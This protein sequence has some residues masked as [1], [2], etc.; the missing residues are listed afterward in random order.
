[1]RYTEG[2]KHTGWGFNTKA[3]DKSVRPQD[4]FYSYANGAWIK[5]NTIPKAE[6]R[7]GSFNILRHETDLQL[8][9]LVDELVAKRGVA[10]DSPEQ[11]VRDLYLSGIDQAA[12]NKKGAAPLAPYRASIAK[13]KDHKTLQRAIAE[14]HKIG[15]SAPWGYAVDQDAKN[16]AKYVLHFYQ[17]GLG[18]PDRDYYLKDDPEFV[19]VRTA[20]V[21][22]AKKL[23]KLAG[24][25]TTD[26]ARAVETVM[27]VETELARISMNK[28]DARDA[29]K[30]Y[31]KKTFAQFKRLAPQIDWTTYFRTAKIPT[32]PYVIVTQPDFLAQASHLLATIPLADWRTYL[33]WQLILDTASYLSDDFVKVNFSFFGTTLYGQKAMKPVWRRV[34]ASVNG[35]VGFALG[36]VYVERRFTAAS[37]KKMDLLVSDL[38][39]AY[40]KRMNALDW[41]SSTTKKKA[42]QKLRAVSRKI[43]YPTKW[44]S[45]KGLHIDKKDFFGNIMRAGEFNRRHDMAKLKKPIDRAEWHM[46]PQTVNA[47]CNFSMNE[48]VFPAAF[49]QYPFFDARSDDAVNYAAVGSTIGHELSHAFDDQGSKFDRHGNMKSW[50]T[51]DDKNK[52]EHKAQVLVD[53]FNGFKVEGVSVNGKLTLGENIADLG[54]AVIAYDAYQERLKKTGRHDIDGFTPEQRFFLGFAQQ[55]QELVRPELQKTMALNDPHSPAKFRINAPL[56]HMPEFYAAFDVREGDPMYRAPEERAK[57]W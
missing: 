51:G 45:Y 57:I 15:I 4:D 41:M 29:E 56:S 24:Y 49:L 26:A 10:T 32:V 44:K 1:M 23:L 38:F 36:R 27:R 47:Y 53:Q 39:A 17:S 2:M 25:S 21:V 22:F 19:R 20:Y 35:C 48:V 6:A 8:K 54:G 42:I 40:E 3:M 34:L 5:N 14:L 55:E 18:L 28:E 7:W 33:E 52:F 43:G 37:K 50:W 30:T 31:H 11:L 12:R 46:T 9:S 13:I 16:S